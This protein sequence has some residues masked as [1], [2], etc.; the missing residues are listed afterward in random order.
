MMTR[1]PSR[2]KRFTVAWPMPRLAPV[3]T[4]VFLL[5]VSAMV[6]SPAGHVAEG[7]TH[8]ERASCRR[9]HDPEK[10]VPVF[11]IAME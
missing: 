2:E 9:S 3:S 4:M 1:Q 10:W 8:G 6:L 11:G 5:S 7:S